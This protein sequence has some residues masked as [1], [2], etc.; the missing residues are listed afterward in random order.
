MPVGFEPS[1]RVAPDVLAER[2]GVGPGTLTVFALGH[3]QPLSKSRR[4]SYL[5]LERRL[6]LDVAAVRPS[7]DARHAARPPASPSRR[8]RTIL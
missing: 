3:P 2:L 5:P 6:L 7:Y 8:S 4:P 1:P